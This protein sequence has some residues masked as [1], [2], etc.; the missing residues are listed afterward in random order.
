MLSLALLVLKHQYSARIVPSTELP[1]SWLSPEINGRAT[2]VDPNQFKRAEPIIRRETRR[3]PPAVLKR[4][5]KA[6][7]VVKSIWFFGAPYGGTNDNDTVYLSIDSLQRGY[8]S[9][10][11]ARSFH[12]EFS[13]IL[14]RNFPSYLDQAA[15]K[16]T[17]PKG[18]QY[19]SGGVDAIK[20]GNSSTDFD[21]AEAARGFYS[22]YS[23]AEQ[24]EDFNIL[25][26]NVFMGGSEFWK[27]VDNY[28]RLKAKV[29]L[30]LN[31]YNRVDSSFTEPS[32][33][34]APIPRLTY[35]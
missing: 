23:L 1:E 22:K 8:T 35:N 33:R 21:A 14:L 11:I 26:E 34:A 9:D 24:E 4:N 30:V 5:L 15:W 10:Y 29:K 7:H 17:L 19:G 32:L 16:A 2:P 6:V 20:Q 28:P 3:Y 13:S 12:H 27:S 18:F 31:F 25:A